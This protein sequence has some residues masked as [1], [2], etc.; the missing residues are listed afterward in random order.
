MKQGLALSRLSC[1]VTLPVFGQLNMNFAN[2]RAVCPVTYVGQ[3]F[4][5][6]QLLSIGC[7]VKNDESYQEVL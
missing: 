7:F 2:C 5:V 3:L 6:G 4:Y 1:T